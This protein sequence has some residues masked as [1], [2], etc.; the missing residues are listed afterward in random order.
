MA[1]SAIHVYRPLMKP[2]RH[3]NQEIPEKAGQSK[4]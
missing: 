3:V 2:Q 1:N 4:F